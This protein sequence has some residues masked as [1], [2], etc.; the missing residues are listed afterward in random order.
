MPTMMV[1]VILMKKGTETERK[2]WEENQ[3]R[4]A[5]NQDEKAD[6]PKHNFQTEKHQTNA[7]NHT[8]PSHKN[9]RLMPYSLQ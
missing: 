2:P 9:H 3:Y 7:I 8:V 5:F 4:R 6:N 1:M